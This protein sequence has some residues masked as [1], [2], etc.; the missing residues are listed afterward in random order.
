M[1]KLSHT[2]TGFLGPIFYFVKYVTIYVR[3]QKLDSEGNYAV[4]AQRF[5]GDDG[6]LEGLKDALHEDLKEAEFNY[7]DFDSTVTSTW[8]DAEFK[9]SIKDSL[10][11]IL[12][13]IVTSKLHA[14][15][16]AANTKETSEG[17][18]KFMKSVNNVIK[19]KMSLD[20][21]MGDPGDANTP[22]TATLNPFNIDLST[23]S[24]SVK[25][26]NRTNKD[27][28]VQSIT[29]AKNHLVLVNK[30]LNS[31]KLAQDK[32]NSMF[33][34]VYD[35]FGIAT[36]EAL[37]QLN[38][39]TEI[40]SKFNKNYDPNN[41]H[42]IFRNVAVTRNEA[43]Q[44]VKDL[45]IQVG[46]EFFLA[47]FVGSIGHLIDEAKKNTFTEA[48]DGF[49]LPTDG[50]LDTSLTV[51]GNVFIELLEA[52][53]LYNSGN[54]G[55]VVNIVGELGGPLG[56]IGPNYIQIKQNKSNPTGINYINTSI[57]YTSA[58][59]VNIKVPNLGHSS[60]DTY[61]LTDSNIDSGF[62]TVEYVDNT[63]LK[64]KKQVSYSDNTPVIFNASTHEKFTVSGKNDFIEYT[65]KIKDGAYGKR[66]NLQ[67]IDVSQ[68]CKLSFKMEKT[69]DGVTTTK[70]FGNGTDEDDKGFFAPIWIEPQDVTGG[71]IRS[72][73]EWKDDDKLTI[74]NDAIEYTV[75]NC[76][77]VT[78]STLKPGQKTFKIKDSGGTQKTDITTN[79]I[80][81]K[82]VTKNLILA[83]NEKN[84]QNIF[85]DEVFNIR[86]EREADIVDINN[87]SIEYKFTVTISKP[88]NDFVMPYGS[89]L[90]T[91][92]YND[93]DMSEEPFLAGNHL[94]VAPANNQSFIVEYE[95]FDATLE[96]AKTS[97]DEEVPVDTYVI[98]SDYFGATLV[99][100]DNDSDNI[101]AYNTNS[102]IIDHDH[103]NHLDS[104]HSVNT[105]DWPTKLNGQV[106]DNVPIKIR[107]RQGIKDISLKSRIWYASGPNPGDSVQQV[108][109]KDNGEVDDAGHGTFFIKN[110]KKTL[111]DSPW[112]DLST[113][114]AEANFGVY[115]LYVT[116]TV[117]ELDNATKTGSNIIFNSLPDDDGDYI[118]DIETKVDLAWKYNQKHHGPANQQNITDE[119]SIIEKLTFTI[120][121]N[122][123]KNTDVDFYIKTVISDHKHSANTFITDNPGETLT[124]SSGN[125]GQI[126]GISTPAKLQKN[127][128]NYWDYYV[129]KGETYTG[130]FY[131]TASRGIA[132]LTSNLSHFKLTFNDAD[133]DGFDWS[134]RTKSISTGIN[135]SNIAS[136]VTRKVW[137]QYVVPNDNDQAAEITHEELEITCVDHHG[138]SEPLQL[139]R[140][141]ADE[142]KLRF[143]LLDD[144][145]IVNSNTF[146]DLEVYSTTRANRN[147]LVGTTVSIEDIVITDKDMEGESISSYV[148]WAHFAS[149]GSNDK[150]SPDTWVSTVVVETGETYK[151]GDGN[152]NDTTTYLG[153]I[154]RELYYRITTTDKYGEVTYHVKKV[155]DIAGESL[156][157][158][159]KLN[160]D[161]SAAV[162]ATTINQ[163]DILTINYIDLKK[164][165]ADSPTDG[166][167]DVSS[168]T[169]PLG[170]G[171]D[172]SSA[173]L[174]GAGPTDAHDSS[175]SSNLDND[176]KRSGTFSYQWQY[177]YDNN[178]T[179]DWED[180]PSETSRTIDLGQ[181]FLTGD[182]DAAGGW[183]SQALV[184]RKIRVK[185]TSSNLHKT[186]GT[187]VVWTSHPTSVVLN[188]EQPAEGAV[189]INGTVQESPADSN[190][191]VTANI[192]ALFDHDNKTYDDDLDEQDTSKVFKSIT[193][194]WQ[195]AN[196]INGNNPVDAPTTGTGTA[197]S[198]SY[199]MPNSQDIVGKY[200]RVVVETTDTRTTNPTTTGGK[201]TIIS[202]W[203]EIL[204]I[205]DP[206][207]ITNS[208][209]NSAVKNIDAGTLTLSGEVQFTDEDR[210]P[211]DQHNIHSETHVVTH[212]LISMVAKR[213]DDA[214]TQF[215]EFASNGNTWDNAIFNQTHFNDIDGAFT[216][217]M[218]DSDEGTQN[219]GQ[220]P[221]TWDYTI[222]TAK[223]DFL[224][225]NETVEFEYDVTIS[226]QNGKTATQRFKFKITGNNQQPTLTVK[227]TGGA[228]G[229]ATE[230]SA[231]ADTTSGY[232][233]TGNLL[234]TDVDLS[235]QITPSIDTQ[236]V[237]YK[238]SSDQPIALPGTGKEAA[239]KGYFTI[240][241]TTAQSNNGEIN[242]TY[243]IPQPSQQNPD[244]LEFLAEGETLTITNTVTIND[245][246]SE[247]NSTKT[248]DVVITIT[249]TN[250]D[251]TITTEID[252]EPAN[253]GDIS[254]SGKLKFDDIDD[255]DTITITS[256]LTS[257]SVWSTGGTIITAN[258]QKIEAGFSISGTN[259]DAPG[260]AD[261]TY[262]VDETYLNFLSSGETVIL[263]YTVT[264]TDN[265][266]ANVTDTVTFTIT[267]TNDVPTITAVTVTGSLT[268]DAAANQSVTGSFTFEDLDVSSRPNIS[269]TSQSALWD[270]GSIDTNKENNIK[271]YFTIAVPENNTGTVTWTYT[272]SSANAPKF[273][274]LSKDDT[275]TLTNT[276]KV[277]D[278]SGETMPTQDIVITITGTNDTPILTGS[279]TGNITE[280]SGEDGGGNLT[281]TGSL[282]S[283]DYDNVKT[284][285]WKLVKTE[286]DDDDVTTTTLV[287]QIVGTYGTLSIVSGTG[288]WTYV[289]VNSSIQ[290]LN[291]GDVL[292]DAFTVNIKDDYDAAID[293]TFTI[294]IT[295]TND[296]PVIT[297]TAPDVS[298]NEDENGVAK[299]TDVSGLSST[300]VDTGSTATW[301]VVGGGA[302][303]YGT[304][305]IVSGT[306]VWTYV[307]NSEAQ[308][309]DQGAVVDD[310][311]T[312]RV[313]DDK[314]GF[315][316]STITI[317]LT[318]VNDRPTL[319]DASVTLHTDSTWQ[320]MFTG[321][322]LNI[323]ESTLVSLATDIDNNAVLSIDSF[324]AKNAETHDTV[325]VTV[326]GDVGSRVWEYTPGHTDEI[327]FTYKVVDD[328]G[329][330]L[331]EDGGDKIFTTKMLTFNF[332]N[333]DPSQLEI[334][335]IYF[336]T[337]DGN[338]S[339][340][341]IDVAKTDNNAG[342]PQDSGKQIFGGNGCVIKAS[343]SNMSSAGG[344]LGFDS[345]HTVVKQSNNLELQAYNMGDIVDQYVALTGGGSGGPENS[346]RWL[347][348]GKESLPA[349]DGDSFEIK[350]YSIAGNDSNGGEQAEAGENLLFKLSDGSPHDSNFPTNNVSYSVVSATVGSQNGW[351]NQDTIAT[352]DGQTQTVLSLGK[353]DNYPPDYGALGI[354]PG[355]REM[356]I[357]VSNIQ[358]NDAAS[359]ETRK[360]V[361]F[362]NFGHGNV[363]DNFGFKYFQLGQK[364]T[365]TISPPPSINTNSTNDNTP[366]TITINDDD[367]VDNELVV[368]F[369]V[370]DHGSTHTHTFIQNDLN[371]PILINSNFTP[372]DGWDYENGQSAGGV[373]WQDY[374]KYSNRGSTNISITLRDTDSESTI[375][376]VGGVS[377][378]IDSLLGDQGSPMKFSLAY[379]HSDSSNNNPP[380]PP[381]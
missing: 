37:S 251:P 204:N 71:V 99:N 20:I 115:Q 68:F 266:Q 293:K 365:M 202:P 208:S 136:N 340:N 181:G 64:L 232:S 285:T 358:W 163:E 93:V 117:D 141:S 364:G 267:G 132:S 66:T 159:K 203:E 272:I 120:T 50:Y 295:G 155:G 172:D 215:F 107:S 304:L 33:S 52:E 131:V 270:G 257:A 191:T 183:R 359:P 103:K 277:D 312:V 320:S 40:I 256:A 338:A 137:W 108:T 7:D 95:K 198:K 335:T 13:I 348:I 319:V 129:S 260:E 151:I 307:T 317:N 150:N 16:P 152:D 158:I 98:V 373:G 39:P 187:N 102:L 237:T 276:V 41:I 14:L 265:N 22:D 156:T 75:Y 147:P 184:D 171:V 174:V 322:I 283:V 271:S 381:A 321:T 261:W 326:T 339:S 240:D 169:R 253:E 226:D 362:Q 73:G 221:V 273:D 38:I 105:V 154:G 58:P 281:A 9:K 65:F 371:N 347:S 146:N 343:G 344:F 269:V 233:M 369:T 149:G 26:T 296:D 356:T 229:A 227:S 292:N 303:T 300:D 57:Y 372:S 224:A 349:L 330:A 17:L 345:K 209:D 186:N 189:S 92:M 84:A 61:E 380:P 268:E 262:A 249:G 353:S 357:K 193:Y 139:H 250:D 165:T 370:L 316:E 47:N 119:T 205:N 121:N 78:D 83:A 252:D 85:E 275:L 3:E 231:D 164:R 109:Y 122:Y 76:L 11:I 168:Q 217:T 128:S 45:L 289:I 367:K 311:F 299:I 161:S 286:T 302:G 218:T 79:T 12:S 291:E 254:L 284:L 82:V 258:K 140:H 178:G 112:K 36:M 2:T 301:S 325:I 116:D 86:L 60:G 138:V 43:V 111:A 378:S 173:D 210:K 280:D 54:L 162:A 35:S 27:L 333:G 127:G 104:K 1:V 213:A 124:K 234:F 28:G 4:T 118:Y 72:Y 126:S 350:F 248:K 355:W 143:N 49:T 142:D 241:P 175:D 246:I 323:S 211:Y 8:T 274:F 48:D 167:E 309:L 329:A 148:E 91:I 376:T 114:D 219:T 23:A 368:S 306:G 220:T 29:R 21:F 318:G 236:T 264:A 341:P 74:N 199:I 30:I 360:F 144:E 375:H 354:Y 101:F 278:G 197:T 282:T 69:I 19:K 331:Q 243:T 239:F 308:N 113:P 87:G 379:N 179:E 6:L 176:T 245:G 88:D 310:E 222:T 130:H 363:Y 190:N 59:T 110:S 34:F 177:S 298:I 170:S 195:L 328:M 67:E 346:G 63:T 31:N 51:L 97:A 166:T 228:V 10:E 332:P 230:T 238:N 32:T 5:L 279:Q 77:H 81:K 194:L 192:T 145:S 324:V 377:A 182:A 18:K 96:I 56:V 242:W 366:L 153:L 314:G 244:V 212:E 55:S 290:N 200:L 185:V 106:S 255:T 315:D 207:A 44:K 361:I 125:Q 15:T 160:S 94:R 297:S 24:S 214:E 334:S 201:T 235:D 336:S 70:T 294:T 263:T 157:I 90:F 351:N 327:Y 46:C 305:S 89:Y 135:N 313:T 25:W 247:S 259:V 216:V 206:V 287:D 337:V 196:Y 134:S 133:A 80:L 374:F 288:V 180:I 100:S 42:F 352:G 53:G 188:V 342:V 223:I 123:D 62:V 225:K